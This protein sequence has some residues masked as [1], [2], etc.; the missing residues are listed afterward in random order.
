MAELAGL[1]HEKERIP[2]SGRIYL[3]GLTVSAFLI[4]LI[5]WHSVFPE[6][7]YLF[8][9]QNDTYYHLHRA[10]IMLA[11]FPFYPTWT[12]IW[13]SPTGPKHRGRPS[14]VISWQP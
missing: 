2:W 11:H 4:R 5:S 10:A 3:I 8:F 12:I 1:I 7:K 9:Y 13:P 6:G 14:M